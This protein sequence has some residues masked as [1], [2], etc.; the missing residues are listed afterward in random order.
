MIHYQ[1]RCEAD[2]EFDGWFRD[3]A[4]FDKQAAAG[5]LECPQC[6]T[7]KV[8]RA[9]MTPAVP[10]KQPAPQ[11]VAPA[12][13]AAA[14]ASAPAG[15]MAVSGP[16]PVP[17]QVRAALQRLRAEVERNCDYV[18]ADF[19]EEARKIHRG[20]SD[21]RG[22]YGEATSEQAEA[23]GEEGIKIARIPWVPR[24]DG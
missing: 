23:L 4:A 7:S 17:A 13:T 9:L 6:G 1:L 19:A 24:A 2:H 20:E 12:E 10:K 16:P 14:P 11:P 3:S 18:G 15:P 21:K 8:S 5:L 22:I